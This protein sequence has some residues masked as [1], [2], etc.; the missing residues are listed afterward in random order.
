MRGKPRAPDIATTRYHKTVPRQT[1]DWQSKLILL[2]IVPLVATD[3]ALE[4]TVWVRLDLHVLAWTLCLS[5]TL[6]LAAWAL[7]AGT[8]AAASTGAVLNASLMYST[9]QV[10]FAPWRT[11]IVPVLTFLVLTSLATRFGRAKKERLGTAE[12]RRGRL[13][14]QVAANIGFAA[15]V[16]TAAVKAWLANELGFRATL[17][18]PWFA[19]ALAALAEAAA[20][21]I[22]SELG[23]VLG[24]TP[25]MITTFRRVPPG[26][27]GGITIAGTLAGIAAAGIV[28]GA[29]TW[30][31]EGGVAMLAISWAGGVF[32]LLFD[33][34]LGAT[35]E[36]RGWLNNDAVNFISTAS[37]S[38]FAAALITVIR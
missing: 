9:A 13:A 8:A 29:G 30:A 31:V 5:A 10:P 4:T 28:A 16:C 14:A 18:L 15:L 36:R 6:G 32:G 33:S 20:D 34:L 19:I 11:A 21:T 2:L 24:G 1:L 17:A 3:A 23:Q 37:A 25:R 22:S 7:R 27:D 35:A 26:T 38:A 12:A